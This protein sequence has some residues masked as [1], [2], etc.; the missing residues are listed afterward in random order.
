[1]SPPI[2]CA[3]TNSGF[4]SKVTVHMPSSPWNTTSSTSTSGSRVGCAGSRRFAQAQAAIARIN[5]PSPA[6]R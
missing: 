1:M 6:A 4:S 5:S 3:T 2:R